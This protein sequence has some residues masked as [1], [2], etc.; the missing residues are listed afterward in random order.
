MSLEPD[1]D[2]QHAAQCRLAEL[3]TFV[4][5]LEAVI[6]NMVILCGPPHVDVPGDGIIFT[7]AYEHHHYHVCGPGPRT[8]QSG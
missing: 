4:M 5:E 6:T 7:Q 1:G 2:V 3:V 8:E